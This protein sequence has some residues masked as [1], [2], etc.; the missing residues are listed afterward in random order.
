MEAL[1]RRGDLRASP[2]VLAELEAGEDDLYRWAAAQDG[3]CVDPDETEQHYVREV[4]R[5]FPGLVKNSEDRIDADPFVIALA[6]RHGLTVV[7]M[8]A[9]RG[10]GY[11]SKMPYACE[12]LGLRCIDV[13][14]LFTDFGWTF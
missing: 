3:F 9:K 1:I 14:G 7:T 11:Q 4:I 10:Q 5:D 2:M 12:Q 6:K 13:L 8:E